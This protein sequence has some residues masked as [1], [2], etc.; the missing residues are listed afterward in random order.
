MKRK[1][2]EETL[3]ELM[4]ERYFVHK[5]RDRGFVSCP[6]CHT[7]ITTCPHCRHSM[8]LP[9]AQTYPDFLVARQYDYVEC[10]QGEE[11]WN[12]TDITPNQERV[13][14][15]NE[16]N[17]WI[18]LL[19]GTGRNYKGKEVYLIPWLHFKEIR[20]NLLELGIKSVRYQSTEKSRIPEARG[21]FMGYELQYQRGTGWVIPLHHNWWGGAK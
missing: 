17:S 12:I 8:L 5:W 7:R 16:H 10:K 15:E 18:F 14:D 1:E 6:N 20:S 9:K 11:S 21:V 2:S 19:I 3:G 13:L 4:R